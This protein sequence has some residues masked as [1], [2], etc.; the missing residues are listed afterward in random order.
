[1]DRRTRLR[2]DSVRRVYAFSRQHQAEIRRGIVQDHLTHI[3]RIARVSLSQDPELRRLFLLPEERMNREAFVAR[4]RATLAA[5]A[6]R[7]AL[8]ITEG[9]PE[10]FVEEL[11]A[12]L[13]S[14]LEA[15]DEKSLQEA[16]RIGA[17]ADL[18]AVT[19]GLVA[20]VRRRDG[21]NRRRW[22]RDRELLAAWLSAKD[23]R[24]RRPRPAKLH[25]RSPDAG[26][27]GAAVV[28]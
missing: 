15:N 20:V 11:E 3:V 18:K 10:T 22:A 25:G 28:R 17:V 16:R 13:A 24:S 14:Y 8:F 7:R 2:L 19:D 27:G 9:L 5:A 26:A 6:E 12:Q 1:M 4:V 21:I 23:M